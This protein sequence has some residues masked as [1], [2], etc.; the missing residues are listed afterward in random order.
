MQLWGAASTSNIEILETFPIEKLVHDSG[1][2]LVC[3]EYDYPKG[4]A[5]N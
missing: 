1:R 4:F 5:N 3:A 2:T